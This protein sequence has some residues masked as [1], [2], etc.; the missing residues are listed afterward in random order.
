[1]TETLLITITGPSRPGQP[2]KL[3]DE[4]TPTRSYF[5]LYLSSKTIF[6]WEIRGW[7]KAST[8]HT[9]HVGRDEAV[10]AIWNNF[11][12]PCWKPQTWPTVRS[13]CKLDT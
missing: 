4:V 10:R 8:M 12:T 7:N 3:S 13:A 9:E 6:P 2:R 5:L 1:M 11:L